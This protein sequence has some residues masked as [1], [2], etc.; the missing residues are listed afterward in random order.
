MTEQD[1]RPP[2]IPRRKER[3]KGRRGAPK[4]KEFMDAALDAYIRYEA[5][6]MWRRIELV[7]RSSPEI[8][9]GEAARL[10]GNFDERFPYAP[11][12]AGPWERE[13][14]AAAAIPAGVAFA[15]VES[16]MRAAVQDE[17][18]ARLDQGDEPLEDLPDYNDFIDGALG[19]LMEETRGEKET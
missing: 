15:N 8:A 18:K 2:G 3:K 6:R 4:S 10:A 16:A 12:W 9:P 14:L 1:E 19:R 11:L 5:L 17:R 13:V 7:K